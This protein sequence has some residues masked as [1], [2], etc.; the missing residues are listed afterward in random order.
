MES[1]ELIK[2][3]D[4]T[5]EKLC[6]YLQGKYGLPTAPYFTSEKCSYTNSRVNSRTSEGLMIHHVREDIA[7]DLCK[8]DMALGY[9][10]EYQMP[11]NLVYC[12]F[13]E[14]FLLHIKIVEERWYPK[15]RERRKGQT[16]NADK[17]PHLL[18]SELY[19]PGIMFISSDLNGLYARGGSTLNWENNCYKAV[20]D[21]F[22]DY[23]RMAVPLIATA[24]A[25]YKDVDSDT[26]DKV[27]RAFSCD[28]E[29]SVM[30]NTYNA[31][32]LEIKTGKQKDSITADKE[33]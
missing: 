11:D 13:L 28:H 17:N 7:D 30:K 21:N 31:L 33:A 27:L 8:Q 4:M 22:V 14:H 3:E 20:A 15:Y 5:Y 12:N 25:M 6:Q 26:I 9:P 2:Q 19:R 1:K 18:I 32:I 29:G 23:I 10:F 24:L 16:L